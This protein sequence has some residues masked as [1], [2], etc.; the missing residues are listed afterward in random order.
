MKM[1]YRDMNIKWLTETARQ[2]IV[3]NNETHFLAF[4]PGSKP[5]VQ[6]DER[7][8]LE[9]APVEDWKWRD[10]TFDDEYLTAYIMIDE[11][12]FYT[13]VTREEEDEILNGTLFA[14]E[15]DE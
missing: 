10:N 2:L 4:G 8:L 12:R 14:G 3:E 1:E 13:V 7:G 15:N 9:L 6:V 5:E 11:V